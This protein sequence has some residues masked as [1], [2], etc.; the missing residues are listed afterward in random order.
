MELRDPQPIPPPLCTRAHTEEGQTPLLEP[1]PSFPAVLPADKVDVNRAL[2]RQPA[3]IVDNGAGIA[4]PAAAL[5]PTAAV[6]ASADT[7]GEAGPS[8]V[9]P[10][11]SAA[12]K[13]PPKSLPVGASSSPSAPSSSEAARPPSA[14]P[15]SPESPSKRRVPVVVRGRLGQKKKPP[16]KKPI[17]PPPPEPE[18]EDEDEEDPGWLMLLPVFAALAYEILF[19]AIDSGGIQITIM[20]LTPLFLAVKR[21]YINLVN[22]IEYGGE[23][24]SPPP[25]ALAPPLAPP[26]APP[27][28]VIQAYSDALFAFAKANPVLYFLV[29]FGIAALI[30]TFFLFLKDIQTFFAKRKAAA[31]AAEKEREAAEK[32][33]QELGKT[34]AGNGDPKAYQP[35]VEEALPAPLP[36]AE[37]GQEVG[38]LQAGE[39]IET[40]VP[41]EHDEPPMS[42]DEMKREFVRVTDKAEELEIKT[43][44]DKKSEAG[45]A[46]KEELT[47]IIERREELKV[48]LDVGAKT[49]KRPKEEKQLEPSLLTKI[50]KSTFM[51]V[52]QKAADGVM[53]ATLYIADLYSDIQ[54]VT[55]LFD[56]GNVLWGVISCVI[57]VTQFVVVWLRV[58]PYLST[59]FGTESMLYTL[60]LWFGFPWGCLALDVFMFIEPFGLLT[61]L[62]FPEWVRQF[63]PAYKATRLIAEVPF[64]L[65]PPCPAFYLP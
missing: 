43:R 48:L 56:T 41:S 57:L 27:P 25:G 46:M 37:S 31:K 5:E 14:L 10:P 39:S 16:K 49:V 4:P 47:R 18:D 63:I 22:W 36:G 12:A 7:G 23:A 3:T 21:A 53:S 28:D 26:P 61:V 60:F 33:K 62:P 32:A 54:V 34:A 42:L 64:A 38:P 9:V 2:V 51:Q 52:V 45:L 58:L 1:M 65:T 59:T 24:P 17:P 40:V 29:D 13:S 30:G 8:T 44:V 55:M 6:A 19:E 20:F 50:M 35:L 15:T 11:S